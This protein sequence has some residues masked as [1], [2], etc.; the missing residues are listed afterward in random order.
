MNARLLLSTLPAAIRER[1]FYRLLNSRQ[2]H[3]PEL[4]SSAP[5]MLAPHLKMKNLIVG[6]VISGQIAFNGF[7]ELALS[8]EIHRLS[9]AGGLFLDV[10][11][12]LGYFSLLWASGSS[13]N[14]IVAVEASPRN[15]DAINQT[16]R[17][18]NL[19]DRIT[20]IK[21]AAGAEN[22]KTS[23]T[24]GPQD[25]TGWGGIDFGVSGWNSIE[26]EMIRLD[27]YF[28]RDVTI[29]VMK[30]D[31][32]GAE[33]LVLTGCERLLVNHQIK[34]IFFEQNKSRMSRL[35]IGA[36]EAQLVLR[37]NGYTVE[38][39]GSSDGEWVAQIR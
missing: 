35:G 30:I 23:F 13:F 36:E 18:N 24:L 2:K 39:F 26:V 21:K 20:L 3:F 28:G 15:Q 34:T 25:Q 8:K 14:K 5:L 9:K 12:N 7:Y 1:I 29:D 19:Q 38:R 32:E 10:G 11:A 37:K 6:D 31:V 4:F 16:F 27:S 22:K 33:T 17:A